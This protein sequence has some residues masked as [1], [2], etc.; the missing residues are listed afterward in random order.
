[1][2]EVLVAIVESS[3]GDVAGRTIKR[4]HQILNAVSVELRAQGYDEPTVEFLADLLELFDIAIR[5][6]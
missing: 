1:M 3:K 2:G 4:K 6:L 5:V